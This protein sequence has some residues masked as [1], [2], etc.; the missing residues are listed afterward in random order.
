MINFAE[1]FPPRPN[2][3][4]LGMEAR[5]QVYSAL[6]GDVLKKGIVPDAQM[7][8]DQD[9]SLMPS[10]FGYPNIFAALNLGRALRTEGPTLDLFDV[11]GVIVP[12][13]E[14]DYDHKGVKRILGSNI[15][16]SVFMG[17]CVKNIANIPQREIEEGVNNPASLA[18]SRSLGIWPR[19]KALRNLLGGESIQFID[20]FD[21]HHPP[22]PKENKPKIWQAFENTLL[23]LVESLDLNGDSLNFIHHGDIIPPIAP[24]GGNEG[25]IVRWLSNFFTNIG[26]ETNS[27]LAFINPVFP[28][29]GMKLDSNSFEF[30]PIHQDAEV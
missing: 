27:N 11:D 2:L 19:Q 6:T 1:I 25:V 26:I 3:E 23:N 21:R 17:D 20:K 8:N 10:V 18:I 30:A 12:I 15:I 9:P 28:K 5:R 29:S 13:S 4:Q 14:S 16:R 7:L 24:L 22:S